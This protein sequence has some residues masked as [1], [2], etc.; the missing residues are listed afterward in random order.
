MA[1]L[2]KNLFLLLKIVFVDLGYIIVS[3]KLFI[4]TLDTLTVFAFLFGF[5]TLIVKI[6]P[7]HHHKP[8]LLDN[9]TIALHKAFLFFNAQKFEKLPRHNNVSWRGNSGLHDGKDDGVRPII[10]DMVGGYYEVGNAIK[11]GYSKFRV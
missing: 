2:F 6:V 5:I 4:W 10:K 1:N 7:H 3:R 8:P 11:N 9:Y